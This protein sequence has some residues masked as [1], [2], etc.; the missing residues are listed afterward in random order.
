M[1]ST[2]EALFGLPGIA[3]DKVL[4]KMNWVYLFQNFPGLFPYMT[5]NGTILEDPNTPVHTLNDPREFPVYFGEFIVD[6]VCGPEEE[7]GGDNQTQSTTNATEDA[8]S[9]TIFHNITNMNDARKG[10]RMF[11]L[12][13]VISR[14]GNYMFDIFIF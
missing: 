11:L 12:S 7:D 1:K 2:I 9:T 14:T 3:L 10:M 13:R 8:A 6:F 5:Y 4:R